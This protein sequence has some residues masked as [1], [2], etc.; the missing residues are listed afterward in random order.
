[1]NNGDMP[2]SPIT[3]G[4]GDIVVLE[5][6]WLVTGL[7]KREHFAGLAIPPEK[8]ITE[9]LHKA[10]PDGWDLKEYMACAVGYRISEADALLK[11]LE[12]S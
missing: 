6:H 8:L 5:S 2:A 3:D 1:M 10:Y 9:L 12:E 4:D 7:T 11:A